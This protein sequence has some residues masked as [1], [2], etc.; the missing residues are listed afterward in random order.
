MEVYCLV[1]EHPERL[2]TV[3]GR[4]AEQKELFPA[5]WPDQHAPYLTIEVYDALVHASFIHFFLLV[6]FLSY[7]LCSPCMCVKVCVF[8]RWVKEWLSIWHLINPL[9]AVESVLL[10]VSHDCDDQQGKRYIKKCAINLTIYS[11]LTKDTSHI[12][13]TVTASNGLY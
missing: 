3:F 9:H 7:L 8:S 1:S 5:F 13:E 6:A 10:G 11:C 2:W 12:T 4:W